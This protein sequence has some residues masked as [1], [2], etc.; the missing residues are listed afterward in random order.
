MYYAVVERCFVKRNHQQTQ[1][2]INASFPKKKS[3][4]MRFENFE[5]VINNFCF[6]YYN[7]T[8]LFKWKP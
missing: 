7:L 1:N 8:P 2:A 6:K 4:Y 5:F 3:F